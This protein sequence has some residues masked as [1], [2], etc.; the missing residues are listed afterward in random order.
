MDVNFY[1]VTIKDV[2]VDDLVHDLVVKLN[3]LMGIDDENLA[4]VAF[5]EAESDEIIARFHDAAGA[6]IE[7]HRN[8]REFYAQ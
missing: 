5:T 3:A 7:A 4:T 8:L 1:E 6:V 2:D